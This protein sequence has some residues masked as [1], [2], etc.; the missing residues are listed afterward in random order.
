MEGMVGFGKTDIKDCGWRID[1]VLEG[2][3]NKGPGSRGM[4]DGP[5][6]IASVSFCIFL[7]SNGFEKN[8]GYLP[9][10]TSR[11]LL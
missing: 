1:E 2:R 5:W 9:M 6:E 8:W 10:G 11:H 7:K 4:G 3:M